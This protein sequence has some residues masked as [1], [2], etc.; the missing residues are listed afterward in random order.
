MNRDLEKMDNIGDKLTVVQRRIDEAAYDTR[1]GGRR[2]RNEEERW[3]EYARQNHGKVVADN[4][5]IIRSFL[6][7]PKRI[8]ADVSAR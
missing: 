4:A 8:R 7:L 2:Q 1:G 5:C 3:G 6:R